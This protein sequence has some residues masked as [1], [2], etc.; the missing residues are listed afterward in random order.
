VDVSERRPRLERILERVTIGPNL[1]ALS[2][3][4]R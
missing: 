1:G 4:W 2:Y 3:Q